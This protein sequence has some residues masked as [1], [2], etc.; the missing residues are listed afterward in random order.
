MRRQVHA[1]KFIAIDNH[2]VLNTLL[3][4]LPRSLKLQPDEASQIVF[5]QYSQ[6]CMSQIRLKSLFDMNNLFDSGWNKFE[7][8]AVYVCHLLSCFAE[9]PAILTATSFA[10]PFGLTAQKRKIRG[11]KSIREFVKLFLL[12]LTILKKR[13]LF[14]KCS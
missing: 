3:S 4:I 13:F 10:K 8:R 12:G 14:G 5:S 1:L 9:F 11:K 2:Y 6:N 7:M